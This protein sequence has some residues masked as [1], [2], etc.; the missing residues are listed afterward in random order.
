MADK[1]LPRSGRGKHGAGGLCSGT[2][3]G[4]PRRGL[5]R[6]WSSSERTLT[7]GCTRSTSKRLRYVKKEH[8][9]LPSALRCNPHPP[10][11]A[12]C[13]V[14]PSPWPLTT[15]TRKGGRKSEGVEDRGQTRKIWSSEG[16]KTM[17]R[18]QRNALGIRGSDMQGP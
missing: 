15:A 16:R 1:R 18:G 6:W 8:H 7:R 4:T 3:R 12:H 17:R 13:A 2:T 9:G 5:G 14:L 10:S 11:P